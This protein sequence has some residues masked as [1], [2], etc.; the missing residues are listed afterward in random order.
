MRTRAA[1]RARSQEA[2]DKG[3]DTAAFVASCRA[4]NVAQKGRRLGLD[5]RTTN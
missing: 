1:G 2:G 3:Y 4:L 5:L